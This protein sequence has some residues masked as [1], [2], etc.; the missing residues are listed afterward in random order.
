VLASAHCN[1]VTLWLQLNCTSNPNGGNAP[2]AQ[3]PVDTPD[4]T[5]GLPPGPRAPGLVQLLRWV[6]RPAQ[7]LES[8]RR[9]YGDNFTLRLAGF[10]QGGFRRVVFI[11]DPAAIKRIYTGGPA[12]SRVAESRSPLQAVFGPRSVL[13]VDGAGHLRQRKLLLPPFH[14]ERL[15]NY[16]QAMVEITDQELV[17]WP[18]D[19]PFPLQPRMQAITL[20]VI[21]RV[22]FGLDEQS[23][24]RKRIKRMLEAV[25]HPL[26]E[27]LMGF[28]GRIGPFNIRATVERTIAEAD[29]S[30]LAEIARRRADPRMPE[31]DDV[32]SLLLQARDE[33]GAGLTDQEL[34]D[35]LVT[36]LLAGHETT[37][38]ALAWTFEHL[39][40]SP[41]SFQRLRQEPA[42]DSDYLK[43][44]VTEV[45]R[46]RP[47]LPIA[48]RILDEPFGL[49]GY[50]LPAGTVITPCIYLVHRRPDLYPDPDAFD[51]ERFLDNPAENY[52][53]L[54]FG[55]GMRRCIGASF[56]DLEMRVVLSRI[57]QRA[58]L[59]PASSRP[60]QMHRRAIV[61]APRR[62]VPALLRQRR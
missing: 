14:G 39:F 62:G 10:G 47:P 33:D 44:V 11:A 9:H 24:L 8:C 35:E 42:E 45:L 3:A 29:E 61:L 32:L 46:L 4:S 20:E 52:T 27:L 50:T 30:L 38:T 15:A 18:L 26:A 23:D 34:R 5:P 55:G 28:P 1:H 7:F 31:R 56:A 40:R 58:D 60:E 36:L 41:D 21:L 51:P 53:W 22:V 57:L 37:A 17:R 25:A 13:V 16:R 6:H 48:D 19:E 54:P 59:G 49:N 43:A 12:L 2:L